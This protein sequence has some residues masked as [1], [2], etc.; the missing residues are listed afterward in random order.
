MEGLENFD[1]FK[2]PNP[3]NYTEEQLQK[4]DEFIVRNKTEHPKLP[5]LWSQWLWDWVVSKTDEERVE[6]MNQDKNKNISKTQHESNES[7]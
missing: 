7:A 5:E 6:M 1:R 2:A 4:R 3:F